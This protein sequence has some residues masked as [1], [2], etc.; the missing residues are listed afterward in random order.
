MEG[1]VAQGV[2]LLGVAA[3]Y[4]AGGA[5]FL[6]R[7]VR[8]LWPLWPFVGMIGLWHLEWHRDGRLA[9]LT[10]VS[11]GIDVFN[12][13]FLQRVQERQGLGQPVIAGLE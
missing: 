8:R 3:L 4:A 13:V 5:V 7:G 11:Q 10:A 12:N 2:A 1:V 9:S 6:R